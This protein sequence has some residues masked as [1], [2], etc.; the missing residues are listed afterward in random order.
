MKSRRQLSD[1]LNF[2][3]LNFQCYW[4]HLDVKLANLYVIKS[5]Q[6]EMEDEI[7]D[8][9][10]VANF[11]RPIPDNRQSEQKR[12]HRPALKFLPQELHLQSFRCEHWQV[13]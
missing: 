11:D 6:Q 9:N 5:S 10:F 12:I 8:L 2:I 3:Q 4:S 1:F 13:Y 7:K